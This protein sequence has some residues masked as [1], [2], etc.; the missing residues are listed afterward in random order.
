MLY[1]LMS[2][3]SVDQVKAP[4]ILCTI[5]I[6]EVNREAIVKELKKRYHNL[7]EKL[8]TCIYVLKLINTDA[9]IKL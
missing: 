4:V 8:A 7:E 2:T 6:D 1:A 9:D 3:T 5:E